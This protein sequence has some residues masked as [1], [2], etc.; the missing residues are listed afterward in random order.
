MEVIIMSLFKKKKETKTP[1]C[2]CKSSGV[3]EAPA[4]KETESCCS[5]KAKGVCC[6]KVLGSGCASCHALY[7][8]ACK[9]VK[10]AGLDIEVEYITDLE[11]IMSYGVMSMPALVVNDNVVSTG[12]VLRSNEICEILL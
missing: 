4:E 5:G 8:N 9:A 10:D 3:C 7:E 11:K 12:K 1:S 2:C 6:V